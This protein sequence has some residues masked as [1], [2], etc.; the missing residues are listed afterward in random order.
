MCC[1]LLYIKRNFPKRQ[2]TPIIGAGHQMYCA[3]VG[4]RMK[5][6]IFAPYI[7]WYNDTLRLLMARA[8]R[9]KD[10]GTYLSGVCWL[11]VALSTI[12][13]VCSIILEQK[14]A[15]SQESYPETKL[16]TKQIYPQSEFLNAKT[17][18]SF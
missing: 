7:G 10:S 4:L 6:F 15:Q 2:N 14:W 3:C 5:V 11:F 13:H 18:R 8:I 1:P 17:G 16:A 9:N 12:G